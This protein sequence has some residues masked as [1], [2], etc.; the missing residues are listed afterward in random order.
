MTTTSTTL[1]ALRTGLRRAASARLLLLL[2]LAQLAIAVPAAVVLARSLDD[3][4]GGSL[5][6]RGMS[7]GFDNDWYGELRVDAEGMET[8]FSPTVIGAAAPLA[9]LDDWWSGRIV[10]DLEPSVVALG[11]AW[12]IVWTLLAGGVLDRLL[13]P[14]EAFGWTR[15]GAA[16]GRHALRL[17]ALLALSA[18]FYWAVYRLSRAGF[19]WLHDAVRDE[20]REGAVM[21]KVAVGALLTVALLALVR[22]VFDF[23]RIAAVRDQRS[24]PLTGLLVGLRSVATRPFRAAGVVVATALLGALLLAVYALVAPGAQGAGWTGVAWTLLVGQLF[25]VGRLYLR[26]AL[27]GAEVA[28]VE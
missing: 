28:L 7:R 21:V 13:R 25:L 19:A 5:A 14:E 2:W 16:A 26:V 3:A 8:T 6:A 9:N 24:N 4:F 15:F 22:T 20:T 12:A 18:P 17:L 23:A 1:G 11:I 10:S 27:L